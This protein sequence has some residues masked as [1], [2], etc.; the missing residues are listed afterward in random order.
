MGQHVRE[1]L[2]AIA[3]ISV[4]DYIEQTGNNELIGLFDHLIESYAETLGLLN[5]HRDKV[6]GY[7]SIAFKFSRGMTTTSQ[8]PLITREWGM[9]DQYYF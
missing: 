8:S 6:Y 5:I 1:Y 4:R 9:D 3:K 2:S 7:L